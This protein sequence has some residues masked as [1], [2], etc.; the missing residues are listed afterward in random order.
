MYTALYKSTNGIYIKELFLFMGN[1]R[2]SN[3]G[4]SSQKVLSELE[5]R[6]IPRAVKKRR[7]V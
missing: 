1:C 5:V 4:E 7:T 3:K 6:P 2:G